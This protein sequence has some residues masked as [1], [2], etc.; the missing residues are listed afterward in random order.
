MVYFQY[1]EYFWALLLLP[2]LLFVFIRLLRWKRKTIKKIGDPELVKDLIVEYSPKKFRLKFVMLSLA[3]ILCGFGVAGLVKPDPTQ[4]ISRTGTDMI[5]TLDVSKSML[6]TDIKPNRLERAKQLIQKLIDQMPDER[7][8]FVVFAGRAY[9]QM[10]L[11]IDHEAAKMIISSASPDNVPY[12]GTVIGDALRMSEAAFDPQSKSFKS[13]LLISDGED[14]DNTAESAAKD[15]AKSGIV[16]NTVGIGSPSGSPIPDPATGQYKIDDQGRTVISKL[17]EQELSSI[18][19]ITHGVYQLYDNPDVVIQGIKNQLNS[20]TTGSILSDSSYLAFFQYYWYFLVAAFVLLVLEMLISEKKKM[21]KL[22]PAAFAMIF[23]LLSMNPANAQSVRKD[24]IS[25][26]KF[27]KQGDYGKAENKYNEALEKDG[28]NDIAGFN[29]GN[30][31]YRKNKPD[32]AEKYYDNVISNTADNNLKQQAFYNKGVAF[33]KENKLPECILAYKNALLLN[34]ND[35]D[36][37]QNLQRVL[38]KQQEQ[39][40]NQKNNQQNNKNNQQKSKQQPQP[41]QPKPSPSKISQKDAEEKLKAL[42]ENEKQLQDKYH[43]VQSAVPD[44]PTKDW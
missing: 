38:K 24:I 6:A 15:L 1:T 20:I 7:I 41:Q 42:M 30:T 8:G 9:L 19:S 10:P 3:I 37:R 23:I 11:T 44:K 26:N 13:V 16:V 18:A 36:A 29:M 31:L 4:K 34:P 25:G 40:Q 14:F 17:N 33:Q 28:K 5:I 22:A 12:Q 32:D 35:E 27:F 39:Q 43:K 2:L 21:K